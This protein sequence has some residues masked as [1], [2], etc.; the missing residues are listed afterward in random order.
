MWSPFCR[1]VV[2]AGSTSREMNEPREARSGGLPGFSLASLRSYFAWMLM[3]PPPSAVVGLSS[4]PAPI[5]LS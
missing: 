1:S 2:Y 3:L 5:W 4:T